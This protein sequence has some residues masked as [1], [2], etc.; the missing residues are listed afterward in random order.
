MINKD[1]FFGFVTGAVL[2]WFLGT[3]SILVINKL[4]NGSSNAGNDR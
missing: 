4:I 1:F 3:A 2:V